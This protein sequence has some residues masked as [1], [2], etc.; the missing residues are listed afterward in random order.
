MV[1]QGN[2]TVSQEILH[3]HSSVAKKLSA[4]RVVEAIAHRA[5]RQR[6][7]PLPA[8][9]P[10]GQ[11]LDHQRGTKM[12][13]HRPAHDPTAEHVEND[14]QIQEARQRRDVG[15]VGDPEPVRSGRRS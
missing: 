14:G 2:S 4:N 1:A 10:E 9:S 8:A 5:H 12:P 3:S 6:D 11:R 7:A 15:D 13:R